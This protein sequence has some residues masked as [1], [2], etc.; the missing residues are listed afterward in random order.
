MQAGDLAGLLLV[1]ARTV[2]LAAEGTRDAASHF[3]LRSIHPTARSRGLSLARFCNWTLGLSRYLGGNIERDEDGPRRR[4]RVV[5]QR[6]KIFV[7][8]ARLGRKVALQ[9]YGR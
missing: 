6:S 9:W 2:A 7:R 3:A 1:A 8:D 5:S 4:W